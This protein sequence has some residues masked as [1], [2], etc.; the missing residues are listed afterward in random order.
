MPNKQKK[1]RFH[2]YRRVEQKNCK[3]FH[4][5]SFLI[6]GLNVNAFLY[7]KKE[8]KIIIKLSLTPSMAARLK[9]M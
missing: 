8:A 7:V 5:L 4:F 2:F 1:N 6:K 9:I 3:S